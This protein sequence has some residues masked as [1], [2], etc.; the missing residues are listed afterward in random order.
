MTGRVE[1]FNHRFD[2]IGQWTAKD[3]ILNANY[4]PHFRGIAADSE[5]RLYITDIQNNAII[6]IRPIKAPEVVSTP[7]RTPP[8]PTPPDTDPYGGQGFPIR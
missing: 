5:N 1:F 3:D 2:F 7:T 4:H 6:R 8:T